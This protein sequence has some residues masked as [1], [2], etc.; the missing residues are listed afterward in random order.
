MAEAEVDTIIAVKPEV[1][2]GCGGTL[3]GNDTTPVRHQ[4]VELPAVRVDVTEYQQHELT[5]GACKKKTRGQLPVGVP[6]TMCGPRLMAQIAT[7]MGAYRLSVR[8]VKQLLA[9]T[10]GLQLST[11]ML[12]KIRRMVSTALEAPVQAVA[13]AIAQSTRVHA[14]ET[15]W[16]ECNQTGY[17]W[18][19]ATKA[20]AYFVVVKSRCAQ[21]AK[22]VLGTLYP[23]IVTTDRYGGYNFVAGD[24]RQFCWAH[25]KRLFVGFELHGAVLLSAALQLKTRQLFEQCR[26]VRDGTISRNTFETQM[27]V[28]REDVELLLLQGLMHPAP[29]V[30]KPCRELLKHA[31]SL[32]TFVREPDVQVTNNHAEQLLRHAV[33]WRKLSYGTDSEEGSLFV[34]RMLTTVQSCRLQNRNILDFVTA[35]CQA[36]LSLQPT[37]SLLPPQYLY[38]AA[39]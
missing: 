20:L 34:G 5:C 27:Q 4:V 38:Q 39:A 26:R 2:C 30:S 8:Q 22:D 9:D 16:K 11:G 32:W 13:D 23:G 29:K 15:G 1:C 7:Y 37:P 31:P 21:V 25:L 33:I 36:K 35:A 17:V 24:K 28:I 3:W 14:D 6:T 10:Y 12:S 18:V 19:F